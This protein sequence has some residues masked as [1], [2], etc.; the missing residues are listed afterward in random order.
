MSSAS[1]P[2]LTQSSPVND[3]IR[4]L[5]VDDN[6]D[7]LVSLEAMLEGLT[8][9]LML[10][11]SGK[12]ALRHVLDYEDFAAILLDV[13]MPE[14]DGFETAELIRSRRQNRNTPILFL[15]GFRNDEQL[16][17]GYDLGA[18]DFLFKPVVPEI[19]RSKV[20]VFVEMARNNQLLRQQAETLSKAELKFRSLLEAAPDAM[21]ITEADGTITL[22]N[23]HM[24]N[25]FGYERGEVRGRNVRLLVPGWEF[26][27]HSSAGSLI[28]G[29]HLGGPELFASRKDGSRFPIEI[30]LSPLQTE[31]GL[32]I[33]TVVRDITERRKAEERVRKLNA[34]LEE[35]VAIRTA[36]LSRSNDAL[37][38]F[39][40][41]A[42]H[43]LQEPLRMVVAYSQWLVRDHS[44]D[45]KGNARQFLD[46][47]ITGG[48]RMHN[49]LAALRE[50]MQVSD[51]G[52]EELIP[53]NAETSLRQAL[54][55]LQSTIEES[56]AIIE[57]DPMPEIL[58]VPV[59]LVQVFQN[60]IGN[61]IRYTKPGEAPRIQVWCDREASDY[62]FSVKDNGIGIAPEYHDRVFGVFKRLQ[63][64]GAG[65]GI[66]LAVCKAA[67]E[68]WGGRIWVESAEGAGATFR[69]TAPSTR[70][71]V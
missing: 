64:D 30:S 51:S 50:Y 10:A 1:A 28:D 68:R 22:V 18:V 33:T 46:F 40:W 35:R 31:E 4:L 53:V 54:S 42:S 37:R 58:G 3:K 70:K 52:S 62:V 21:L 69:F 48:L 12:E 5:L 36:E 8:D 9:E 60:L 67:V 43:D 45:L 65:T 14:M 24:H 39:A 55:N 23:A 41:A 6:P 66:G 20:A 29:N 16:F 57:S 19:L 59:L 26:P 11:R 34:E 2:R 61:A 13:K 38:Q 32:L 7:N 47:I 17:R 25:L 49:L 44:R 15:T 71:S 27:L 56:G 63:N